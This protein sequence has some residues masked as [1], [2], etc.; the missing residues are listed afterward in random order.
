MLHKNLVRFRKKYKMTQKDVAD[1]LHITPQAYSRYERDDARSA[2]PSA[3]NLKVLADLF[4]V[5]VD[6]LLG[7]QTD[8]I[9]S[10]D[11]FMFNHL[12]GFSDLSEE[13]QERIEQLLIEQA[14]FLIAKAK[15]NK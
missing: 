6:E 13:E 3:E 11:I 4:N 2:E 8:K 15:K 1:K 10:I 12:E 7:K 14:E 9:Q 5:S